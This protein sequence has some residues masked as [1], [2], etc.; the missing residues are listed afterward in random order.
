MQVGPKPTTKRLQKVPGPF[1]LIRSSHK[2]IILRGGMS[3]REEVML[4]KVL[5]FVAYSVALVLLFAA[6]APAAQFG[7]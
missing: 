2:V 3:T 7:T 6:R 5:F 1:L 4:H